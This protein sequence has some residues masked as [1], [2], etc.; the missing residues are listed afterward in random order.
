MNRFLNKKSREATN[1][2]F[3]NL[4]SAQGSRLM[5][6]SGKFRVKRSGIRSLLSLSFAHELILMSWS[7]FLLVVL[8]FYVV[9]NTLFAALYYLNGMEEFMGGLAGSGPEA[10]SE[11][12]FFSAQTLT[13]VGYGR[14][15]PAGLMANILASAEALLGLMSFAL[16]T[17]LLY[18]RFAR[19]VVNMQYSAR[20][21]ISP[22]QDGVAMMLRL[23]N[24]RNNDLAEVE[25]DVI[26]S[27][28]VEE[29]GRTIRKYFT[30]E[31]ERSKVTALP[32]TWTLVHAIRAESPLLDM[33][34]ERLKEME[35]EILVTVKGLDTTFSQTVFSR[36]SYSAD[37]FVWNAR[38]LPCFHRSDDGA[39]TI[40]EMDKLGT[41]ELLT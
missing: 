29:G 39:E 27:L 25:A 4:A 35:G 37:S 30:L 5:D 18:G 14:V 28:L 9:V 40:L 6:S 32:L 15:N 16:V 34:A 3:S 8:L 36:H 23:A 33:N 7:R 38:F 19:P 12:F 2:G 11:A 31:L 20:V 24:A 22:Y 13:T 10:F 1:T 17:G 26:L 21:L 41:Y